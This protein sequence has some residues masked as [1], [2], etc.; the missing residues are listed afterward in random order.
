MCI[1]SDITAVQDYEMHYV[2]ARLKRCVFNLDLNRE[3]V[4]EPPNVIRKAIPEFGSQMRKTSTSFS[5]LRYP[6]YFNEG[7]LG[8]IKNE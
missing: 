7:N 6:R 1:W 3:S 2:N 5:G 8:K 4:S